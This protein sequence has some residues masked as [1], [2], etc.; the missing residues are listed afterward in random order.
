MADLVTV[1]VS[2][3]DEI[4]KKLKLLPQRLGN[5]A[6]KRA[7]RKGANVIKVQA[8]ANAQTIDDP[9]TREN[10]AKNIAVAAG[11]AKRSR[12][13]GGLLMRV[14]VIGGARLSRGD[15]G[16]PGGNTTHWR[17]VEFGTATVPARPFMRNAMVSASEKAIE[18]T[19]TSMNTEID[20]ELAKLK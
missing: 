20:K 15:N 5:N 16:A 11:S 6:L 2:G 10:I 8:Q 14:G 1:K 19:A 12:D 3:L 17:F 9:Q 18:V 13:A 7:L 4:E